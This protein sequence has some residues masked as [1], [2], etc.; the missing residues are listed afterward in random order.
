MRALVRIA[1]P[2]SVG[3]AL[4]GCSLDVDEFA[5]ATASDARDDGSPP[6]TQASGDG[7]SDSTTAFD[8]QPRGDSSSPVA[9]APADVCTCVRYNGGGK[10]KEWSPPNC[11]S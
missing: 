2:V 10:C 4:A 7:A 9:D 1:T 5:A 8:T 3:L 6:E 11:G